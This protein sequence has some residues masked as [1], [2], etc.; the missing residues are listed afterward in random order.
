MDVDAAFDRAIARF[1]FDEVR[2]HMATKRQV[3]RIAPLQGELLSM[4]ETALK[5][6]RSMGTHRQPAWCGLL[7]V[8][9]DTTEGKLWLGCKGIGT[10]TRND[11]GRI[12][13]APGPR[14]RIEEPL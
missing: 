8:G 13:V 3:F 12:K 6:A 4:F 9:V 7:Y 2:A 5:Y 1:P 10:R 14:W 11:E